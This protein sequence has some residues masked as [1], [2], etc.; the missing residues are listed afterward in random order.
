MQIRSRLNAHLSWV[1]TIETCCL[2]YFI[3]YKLEF[4]VKRL[5][6]NIRIKAFWSTKLLLSPQGELQKHMHIYLYIFLPYA[7]VQLEKG[8]KF[9]FSS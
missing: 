4:V 5:V 7:S 3:Q 1:L 9:R 8:R 6:W 2:I